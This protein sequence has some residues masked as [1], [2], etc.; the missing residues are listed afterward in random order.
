MLTCLVFYE[1][2]FIDVKIF[3]WGCKLK[4]KKSLRLTR[5][6]SQTE[7][8]PLNPLH[9]NMNIHILHT[10]LYTFHKVLA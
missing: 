7:S 5:I 4:K 3:I 8:D 1:Q 6:I 9:P 2:D 10:V